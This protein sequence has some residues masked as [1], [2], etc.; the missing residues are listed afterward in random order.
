MPR[1]KRAPAPLPQPPAPPTPSPPQPTSAAD[2]ACLEWI[3]Y[4]CGQGGGFIAAPGA[5]QPAP[6]IPTIRA[7]PVPQIRVGKREDETPELLYLDTVEGVGIGARTRE[8][9]EDCREGVL[10]GQAHERQAIRAAIGPVLNLLGPAISPSATADTT[11]PTS[12][13]ARPAAGESTQAK[14][15]TTRQAKKRGTVN[16]RMLEEMNRTPE[17]ALWSLPKWARFL[18]CAKSTVSVSPA[19]EKCKAVRVFQKFEREERRR[20]NRTDDE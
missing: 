13:D 14:A 2:P 1:R 3:N 6:E 16:Q 10:Q 18:K 4:V 20:R 12:P 11:S 8:G 19:W 5:T 15:T 7:R 17:S 9:L